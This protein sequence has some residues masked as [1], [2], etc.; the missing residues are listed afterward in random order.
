MRPAA[1]GLLALGFVPLVHA[2]GARA[3]ELQIPPQY[4]GA[5]E[6]ANRIGWQIYLHDFAAARATDALFEHKALPADTRVR[7]WLTET[8]EAGEDAGI[9]VTFIGEEAGKA[10]ALYR[11][12]VAA[13][14]RPIEYQAL[15]PAAPLTDVQ[16]AAW[17]A[18]ATAEQ[19]LGKRT[20]LCGERYNPVVLPANTPG[21]DGI[22]VYMLAATT[23]PDLMVAGGHFLYEFTSDGARL[24]SERAFT[25]ACIDMPIKEDP[26]KGKLQALTLTHL[27]DP[28]PTEIHVFLGRN[29]GKSLYLATTQNAMMWIIM[30]GR[31]I[32]AKD[33]GKK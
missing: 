1:L 25:R 6:R 4:S 18:R 7:G 14:D 2:Q 31:I 10:L 29:Y 9:D 23:Q 15:T 21:I 27:L 20:D 8:L 11:V 26:A 5:V 32:A 3:D 17:K 12:E 33:L 19:A 13:G 30:D 28:T 24:K 16:A 22:R